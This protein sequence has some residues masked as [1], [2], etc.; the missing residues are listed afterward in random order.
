IKFYTSYIR[1][2]PT[3]ECLEREVDGYLCLSEGIPYEVKRRLWR[4]KERRYCPVHESRSDDPPSALSV[5]D[6]ELI[7]TLR[8]RAREAGLQFSKHWVSV[9][10]LRDGDPPF[11]LRPCLPNRGAGTYNNKR[12][13][14]RRRWR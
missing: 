7:E 4:L 13:T 3:G 2:T 14:Y 12:G 8:D 5:A 1:F 11:K 10:G 6:T 9:P